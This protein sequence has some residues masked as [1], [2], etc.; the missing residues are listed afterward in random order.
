MRVPSRLGLGG[1][2][3]RPGVV[4]APVHCASGGVERVQRVA[5]AEDHEIGTRAISHLVPG[6]GSDEPAVRSDVTRLLA[7]VRRD[8]VLGAQLV[9]PA[10]GAGFEFERIEIVV[11]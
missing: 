10:Q 11:P 5:A 2:S 3:G 4:V 8:G 6:R 1:W 9:L 7:R